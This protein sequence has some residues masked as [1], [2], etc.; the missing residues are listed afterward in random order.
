[1]HT[2]DTFFYEKIHLNEHLIQNQKKN[3]KKQIPL[4]EKHI[5]SCYL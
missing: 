1:M 3:V 5:G 2:G 4:I